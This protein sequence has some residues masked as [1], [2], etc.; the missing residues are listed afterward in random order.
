MIGKKRD[1]KERILALVLSL[2]IVVTGI[3]PTS[4]IDVDAAVSNQESTVVA[5]NTAEEIVE[6]PT[7]TVTPTT[8]EI[9]V[10]FVIADKNGNKL[11]DCVVKLNDPNTGVTLIDAEYSAEESK[12]VANNVTANQAYKFTVEKTGYISRELTLVFG[13]ESNNN[14][15]TIVIY[16]ANIE[17]DKNEISTKVGNTEAVTINNQITATGNPV[18]YT[19]S[20]SREDVA[21][22]ENGTIVAKGA[23]NADITV[24]Y[25]EKSATVKVTVSKNN[26]EGFA[27]TVTPSGDQNR[28]DIGQ[29][30]CTV[31]GYP[32]DA[33][34]EGSITYYVNNVKKATV[35]MGEENTSWTYNESDEIM[36][37]LTFK[38]VYSGNTKYEPCTSADTNVTYKK[39]FD[40]AFVGGID[41]TVIKPNAP[42]AD[43]TFKINVVGETKKDRDL[44][45]ESD[46]ETVATVDSDGRV[47]VNEAGKA[48]ITVTAVESGNYVE[49]KITYTVIVQKEI[50]VGDVSWDTFEKIYDGSDDK[51]GQIT[52]TATFPGSVVGIDKI[53]ATFNATVDP[54]AGLGKDATLGTVASIIGYSE[55]DA[56]V[57]VDLSELYVLD[58]LENAKV[59]GRVNINKR[60]VYLGTNDFEVS[61]DD[62]VKTAVENAAGLVKEIKVESEPNTGVVN[63]D[64]IAFSE[65]R[66]TVSPELGEIPLVKQDADGNVGAYENVIIL[67]EDSIQD[68]DNYE[69]VVVSELDGYDCSG[70]LG[71]LTVNPGTTT[72]LNNLSFSAK[73]G[74]CYLKEGNLAEIWINDGILEATLI[75]TE[76]YDS[77]YFVVGDQEWNLGTEGYNIS[78]FI[79][80]DT[81]YGMI[82]FAKSGSALTVSPKVNFSIHVDKKA[83]DFQFGD[84]MPE[85]TVLDNWIGAITFNRF[86]NNNYTIEDVEPDDSKHGNSGEKEWSYYVYKVNDAQLTKKELQRFVNEGKCEWSRGDG[87]SIPVVSGTPDSLQKVQGNYI[88]LV[89]V[90]DNVGNTAVYASN[91]L[92]MEVAVPEVDIVINDPTLNGYYNKDLSYTVTITDA[93]MENQITSGVASATIE[94]LIDGETYSTENVD[95]LGTE[96]KERTGYSLEDLISSAT[97]TIKRDLKVT[98]ADGT[99]ID[100]NN[101]EIKVTAYDR[102]GNVSITE[103]K[104]LKIDTTA[105]EIFVEYSSDA[106]VKNDKYFSDA[107][108]MTITYKEKNFNSDNVKFILSE[109]DDP[110]G[111][112]GLAER[113]ITCV[114]EG[115]NS[116]IDS[117]AVVENAIDYTANRTNTLVLLFDKDGEY[118][119][120]PYVTDLAGNKNTSCTYTNKIAQKEFVIDKTAPEVIID[121]FAIVD[122]VNQN[123]TETI[124]NAIDEATRVYRKEDITATVIIKEQNF[125]I[126]DE[127]GKNFAD[128]QISL[129][130]TESENGKGT[131]V[132]I[133]KNRAENKDQKHW[134]EDGN[135][136]KQTFEFLKDANYTFA[137]DYEDLAGNSCVFKVNGNPCEEGYKYIRYFTADGTDPKGTVTIGGNEDVWKKLAEV[138]TFGIFNIFNSNK[139]SIEV[140]LT[141]TDDTAGI[142]Y[143][144]YYK[145]SQNFSNENDLKALPNNEWIA[146][147]DAD[148]D[149]TYSHTFNVSPN[150]QF[151]IYQ[152]IIDKSGNETYLC[153]TRGAV[154]DAQDPVKIDLSITNR[155]EALNDIFD[156]NVNFHVKIEDPINGGTFSGIEKVWYTVTVN[157]NERNSNE[158]FVLVDHSSDRVQRENYR[159]YEGSF[160]VEAIEKYNSNDVKVQVFATDFSGNKYESEVVSFNID[161][162]DPTIEVSFNNVSPLNGKYYKDTRVATVTIKE[163]NFDKNSTPINITNSDGTPANIQWDIGA[164]GVSD[165]TTHTATITFSADG[166]YKFTVG[167]TDLAGNVTE[168]PYTSEEFTIDKTTPVINVSYDNNSAQNG[169][170]YK[171]ARTATIT[172]NE[173]NF[174]ASDVQV[175]AT[176]SNGSAPRVSGWSNSGDRHTA[177]VYFDS[178]ADYIFDISYT[179]MAGNNAAD[180]AQ[181]SFTVD[182]TNPVVEITGVANKS[183]NKGTVAPTITL[184][185]TNFIGDG[186]TLTLTGANKGKIDISSMVTRTSTETG[187]SITFRNFGDNMDDI[188]TLTAKSVDKAGNETSRTIT[189]SVNRHGSTYE[190]NDETE[191]LVNKGYTNSPVDVVIEEYN[192]DSLEFIELSY[193]KDG[194]IV[195]LTRNK[196]YTV[197]EEGS[198]GQWKKYT[199]TIYAK[200]FE[201]EG[202]YNIN[203]SSVDRAQNESNN[204]VQSMNVA[205]VVDKT[206]PTMA[207]SNLENRGRYTA[208]IHQFTLNVKDNTR[209]SK[210]ELYLDGKLVHTYEGD[211]LIVEDGKIYID[212]DS[213]GEYQTVKLI[214]YDEAG[215]PTE[216]AEYDVLVTSNRWVQFVANKPLFYGAI[217]ALAVAAGFIFF[218]IF[219]KKKKKEGQK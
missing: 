1:F 157:G 172:I 177:T 74:N 115:E 152:K 94:V 91:G 117:E 36:G 84:W 192:V 46:N 6:T 78:Q 170:Y 98:K 57:H 12:Y 20:S 50:R 193:S 97:K 143:A 216:P 19:W 129:N 175:A 202:E 112:D 30:T 138:F 63:G 163:R 51:N 182:L 180:Y 105:P 110:V 134:Q 2:L 162:T 13:P 141:S 123:I 33:I 142:K 21:T 96:E 70:D 42:D 153:P 93:D 114:R 76:R 113:G 26:I 217:V 210:V 219:W 213:K 211:E 31:S 140:R 53:V 28:V 27:L 10:G 87:N 207:I 136:F 75:N 158:T 187:Q 126:E 109:G 155:N 171:A 40:L 150:E 101:V 83:P 35:S 198:D 58:A 167:C 191:K 179:D 15:T 204:K 132:D 186:V 90:V 201:E 65:M 17:L 218:L 44:S 66:A 194:E 18:N 144:G 68:M 168:T 108:T 73:G 121:Y 133:L 3:I 102:A 185:D 99:K 212:I 203:I 48:T 130:G 61:Y 81:V 166:D 178:D 41:K 160:E 164:N 165:A 206:A 151:V 16:Q 56:N 190:L 159:T 124:D 127:S 55:S 120:E 131:S 24:S 32:T 4:S 181:D 147:G 23:G 80:T 67:D 189:F 197:K 156:E 135:G 208:N 125:W 54:K 100:S 195:K 128:G 205:F 69:F 77:V 119:I 9:S 214:A 95:L 85:P 174:N 47:T 5:A 161:I 122:N 29:V 39:T 82:Y 79:N 86:V 88:V 116:F 45:Y 38:A 137:F 196:D 103:K 188:Y 176:A 118:Y 64:S 43:K 169:N 148:E 71:D 111:L 34:T 37:E 183:A 72:D 184:N 173:H 62:D 107:R 14:V 59:A 145:T 89:Q 199:Y 215:N 106:E 8:S 146:Y 60:T 154:A 11:D 52:L 22:V 209:L 49:D 92:V 149:G 139:G 104:Q 200:C 25:G 7:P